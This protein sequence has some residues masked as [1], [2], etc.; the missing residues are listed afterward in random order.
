MEERYENCEN[1]GTSQKV[2]KH[3]KMRLPDYILDALKNNE[4]SLG[5]NP[6]FPPGITGG[7][8]LDSLLMKRFGE[9]S[10][11]FE[12]KP[13]KQIKSELYSDLNKCKEIERSCKP[14]LEKLCGDIV[15]DLFRFP[16]DT[17]T[18]DME[19]SETP[20]PHKMRVEPDN[21]DGF[22]FDSVEDMGNLSSEIYKRRMVDAL[23]EGASEY[24]A[25][26]V[27]NYVQELFKIQPELPSIYARIIK[28]SQFLTLTEDDTDI[29]ASTNEGGYA[30]VKVGQVDEMP[31]VEARGAIFPILLQQSVKGILEI[32]VLGGLPKDRKKARF[33]MSKADFGMAEKW[34]SRLGYPLWRKIAEA[35]EKSGNSLEEVG[36]N[37]VLMELADSNIDVFNKTLQEVFANT[38]KGT[39]I[40]GA[41]C[42]YI[43]RNREQ[44]EFDD[45]IQQQNSKYPIEDGYFTAEELIRDLEPLDESLDLMSSHGH[46]QRK[47]GDLRFHKRIFWPGLDELCKKA[48]MQHQGHWRPTTS[49]VAKTENNPDRA[50][51]YN[52]RKMVELANNIDFNNA[53]I[54][55]ALTTFDI[56]NKV[57]IIR[58]FCVQVPYDDRFNIGI[59]FAPEFGNKIMTAYL[60]KKSDT[61]QYPNENLYIK[62]KQDR[63]DT[64]N[65][66]VQ[67][68]F[69]DSPQWQ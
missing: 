28:S 38:G 26:N 43:N 67:M 46:S 68:G 27:Q 41:M 25:Y 66:Y 50:H 34:D 24:F 39:K 47:V 9:L 42:D 11:E 2:R 35:V 44:D 18:I 15:K 59:V 20:S 19:I 7:R 55:E 37:F 62:S 13:V 58:R 21:G 64:V 3:L 63:I 69:Y 32:A 12:N 40:V 1:V 6:A 8:F 17:I 52:V 22:E 53:Y 30:I 48:Y 31:S 57:Y 16:E 60:K 29:D 4:T 56:R 36:Y 54:Y 23:V 61:Q 33:V 10:A 14:A 49:C 5:D 45:Y 51:Q 65:K